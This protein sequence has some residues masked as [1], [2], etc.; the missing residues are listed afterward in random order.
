MR[1]FKVN[2]YISLKLEGNKTVIYVRGK[3]FYQCKFL[4]LNIPVDDV[5]SLD[6]IES[7]DEAEKR[8]SRKMERNKVIISPETDY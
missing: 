6:E 1:E 5:E 4:L 2:E 8:L 3:R 7:I